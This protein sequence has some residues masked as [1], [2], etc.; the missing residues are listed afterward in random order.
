MFI[1]LN[2]DYYVLL[3]LLKSRWPICVIFKSDSAKPYQTLAQ[4][5][6]VIYD[7]QIYKYLNFHYIFDP[8]HDRG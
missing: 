1:G 3:Q 8:N 6:I 5:F 2:I 4:F 7:Y